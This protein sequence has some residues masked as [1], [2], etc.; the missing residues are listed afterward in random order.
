M[1]KDNRNAAV[2][3]HNNAMQVV[4]GDK[5]LAYRL[6]ASATTVDPTMAQGHYAMG[7]ATA[8]L[9]MRA[10]SIASF[11]RALQCPTGK[12]EH[13][14][15]TA[16]L[17][18]KSQ[19]NLGHRLLN[20]GQIE[21]ALTVSRHAVET[22]EADPSLDQEGRAFAWTNMSL[23]LSIM[24]RN[25]EAL[26][27]AAKAYEMSQEAI[28][29]TG[30]A[31]AL[32]FNGDY[33]EG[34]KRF[35]GRFGYR[36]PQYLSYPYP[37]WDGGPADTLLVE[38]DQGLG[39]TLSFA[40]FVPAA[41]A[42]C[43]RLVF[44]VQPELLRLFATSL[45]EWS[46]IEVIPLSTQF[47]IAD[48]WCPV[49]SL[50]GALGLTTEQIR[51]Y[52][53]MWSAMEWETEIPKGWKAQGPEFHIGIA[54]AGSSMND[55]DRWRSIPITQ[56]L[57]LYRVPGVQL[58]SLQVGDRV[59][60]LHEAGCAS[61]VRDL[62]PWIRDATDT[63]ALMREL[64]LVVTCE[65]FLGHLAGAVD[66]PCWVAVS[67]NGGDWRLGRQGE[68]ALWYPNT[69]LFRQ[70]EDATWASVFDRIVEVLHDRLRGRD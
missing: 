8:D 7:N 10:A 58:Y 32:L 45:S 52:P 54:Y 33:A 18:A 61:L 66:H 1:N 34:L 49:F 38:A 24:G 68:R 55:I 40:R 44:R 46:N 63:I 30:L 13:G 28:I 53:Q 12:A 4:A 42:Q 16:E 14:A 47:P 60:D 69:R 21:E 6:L 22:L 65:S 5:Q 17:Y 29:E 43:K 36:L 67:R 64:D 59:K 9:Q 26:E 41:A 50:P 39:D 37:R 25:G 3:F 35:E 2:S 62:S 15:L 23:V 31:F 51:D 48:V 20:N 70:G 56:F 27:Y 11:R 19:V 57:E